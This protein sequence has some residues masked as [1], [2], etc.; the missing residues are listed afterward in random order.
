MLW[1][2]RDPNASLEAKVRQAVRHYEKKYGARPTACLLHP[3][4]GPVP[5]EVDGVRL[6]LTR[7][8]QPGDMWVGVD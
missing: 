8:I 1:A 5:E 2:D 7:G 4:A 6:G 3:A